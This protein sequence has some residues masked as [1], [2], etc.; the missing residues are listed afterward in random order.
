MNDINVNISVNECLICK[1]QTNSMSTTKIINNTS[2][3]ISLFCNYYLKIISVENNFVVIS[4]DNGTIFYV[5]K[6]YIDIP[7]RICLS[8]GCNRHEVCIKINSI[9]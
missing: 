6:A 3:F 5:R 2:D 9:T 7:S 4:I 1:C 8:D